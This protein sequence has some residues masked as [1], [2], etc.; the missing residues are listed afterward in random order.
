MECLFVFLELLLSIHCKL[1]SYLLLYSYF[2]IVGVLLPIIVFI[3]C[4]L[5]PSEDS[6]DESINKDINTYIVAR[7]VTFVWMIIGFLISMILMCKYISIVIIPERVDSKSQ[8]ED[9]KIMKTIQK[10]DENDG[11]YN[12]NKQNKD[13]IIN[14]DPLGN[15]V[16][17]NKETIKRK[18]E[19]DDEESERL[20]NKNLIRNEDEIGISKKNIFK[21]KEM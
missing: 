20:N 14:I 11:K 19:G 18:E 3:V 21:R 10:H 6:Y 13:R 12:E 7:Y 16:K 9:M 8:K 17:L 4:I 15:T 5:V 1:Y 2:N